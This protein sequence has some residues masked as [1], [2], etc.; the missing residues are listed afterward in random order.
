MVKD[1]KTA[2]VVI[3]LAAATIGLIY[4][5]KAKAAPPEEGGVTIVIY[6]EWGNPVPT[7]SPAILTEGARYTM[8][9][10]VT[11]MTTKATEPPTPWEATLTISVSASVGGLGI[12]TPSVKAE[13]FAAGQTRAFSYALSVPLGYGGL[14]GSAVALVKDPTGVTLD[15]ATEP[16]TVTEIPIDYG[17]GIVIGV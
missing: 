10:T 2:A 12:M 13:Y 7:N 8:V 15:S 3:G 11:N 1:G 4:A 6:D 5:T 16:I 9:V 17:A 14:I